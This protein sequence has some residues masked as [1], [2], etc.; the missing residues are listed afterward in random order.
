MSNL[1]L[2]TVQNLSITYGAK[3]V[4]KQVDLLVR[5]G[6]VVTIVGPN[7]SGKTSLFRAIID[8]KQPKTG[9]VKLKPGLKIGYVPQRLSIDPTFP[10]TVDRFLSLAVSTNNNSHL[11]PLQILGI[12]HLSK[13]QLSDLSGGQFQRV[14]LA[15]ALINKPDILLLDEPTQGLDQSGV[16]LFY[17]QI[18]SVRQD[19]RCAVLM[20]SHDL[21]VV[22]ATSDRV[23]CL[24]GHVCCAGTPSSVASD[25]EYQALFGAEAREAL[26]LYR[27]EHDHDHDHDYQYDNSH[28]VHQ[29]SSDA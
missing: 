16:A 11:H 26:A 23:I 1:S 9:T 29:G 24:N 21:H 14:L 4:L 28:S 27:H 2:I 17:R 15:R 19:I 7:G 5:P 20:I 25:P 6:E 8:A 18:E 10:I 3:T 13:Y 12:K 22:M